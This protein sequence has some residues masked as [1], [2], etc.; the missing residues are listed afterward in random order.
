MADEGMKAF[1]ESAIGGV[2]GPFRLALVV[3]ILA[4]VMIRLRYFRRARRVAARL[5]R[6]EGRRFVLL[7]KTLA[8]LGYAVMAL[9]VLYPPPLAWSAVRL[10]FWLRGLGVALGLAIVPFMV[11]IHR[12]LGRN[13]SATILL[14]DDHALVTDGP[15][16]QNRPAACTRR[17]AFWPPLWPEPCTVW[18][19]TSI[20]PWPMVS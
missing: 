4:F 5:T 14:R 10:P 6:R 17:S 8:Y 20:A 7:F 3:L 15:Y 13:F 18:D 16:R 2:E 11:W 12:S 19:N 9:Y 1:C